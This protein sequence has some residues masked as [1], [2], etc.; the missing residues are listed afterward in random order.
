MEVGH[1]KIDHSDASRGTTPSQGPTDP[2]ACKSGSPLISPSDISDNLPLS[3]LQR[4]VKREARG[5]SPSVEFDSSS[6]HSVHTNLLALNGASNC[7]MEQLFVD[8]QTQSN[9]SETHKDGSGHFFLAAPK[10]RQLIELI[11]EEVENCKNNLKEEIA[12]RQKYVIDQKRRSHNY[13]QFIQKYFAYALKYGLIDIEKS[14]G[15]YRIKQKSSSSDSSDASAMKNDS[16]LNKERDSGTKSQN[17]LAQNTVVNGSVNSHSSSS[18][19]VTNNSSAKQQSKA[20]VTSGAVTSSNG[21]T[22]TS[23]NNST[24]NSTATV[25]SASSPVF[26]E[27]RR[28]SKV[29]KRR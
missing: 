14:S 17:S 27:N 1:V 26:S 20:T 5:S 4:E 23:T 25:R 6:A 11:D 10:I 15:M 7:K 18:T 24:M 3:S 29:P 22:V 8:T 13:Q 19:S 28:K 12:R 9:G 2:N 21:S 16:C